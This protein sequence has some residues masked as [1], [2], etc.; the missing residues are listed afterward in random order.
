MTDFSGMER[1]IFVFSLALRML[2]SKAQRRC[3]SYA[4]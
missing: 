4:S 1:L 2:R 3:G